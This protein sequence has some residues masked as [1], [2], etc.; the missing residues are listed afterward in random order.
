MSR[1]IIRIHPVDEQFSI[2]WTLGSFCNY[3]C[4]YCPQELH[5]T[6][7]VPH[8]LDTLKTAWY[9]IYNSTRQKGLSYKINFS[10]GEVTANRSFLPFVKWLRANFLDISFI[11]ITT[12]GSASARY[13]LKLC[14]LVESIS[15]S[16]HSEFMD[17][18]KFFT[19]VVKTNEV[20]HRP[21]KSVHVNIMN[22]I[23]NQHRIA[24]YADFLNQRDISYSINEINYDTKTREVPV[25][26]G[27]VNLDRFPKSTK[28]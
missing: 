9:N 15:F 13:Y 1:K 10:G 12:N 3:D 19:N 2:T 20:M 7:S 28:L 8:N 11:G 14:E 27:K 25:S 23:W 18:L 22:E 26:F 5:D 4:M 16:T 21:K 17:E 6:Q 24:I